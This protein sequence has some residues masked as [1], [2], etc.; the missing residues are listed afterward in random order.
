MITYLYTRLKITT[1]SRCYDHPMRAHNAHMQEISTHLEALA[2]EG[3]HNAAEVHGAL[4]IL[5]VE[6]LQL[7]PAQL[8][9]LVV[10]LRK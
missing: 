7:L 2:V 9:E 3:R 5:T 6:L 4:G 10:V 1:L 8:Q